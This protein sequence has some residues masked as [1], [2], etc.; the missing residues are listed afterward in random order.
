MNQGKLVVRQRLSMTGP[1][2]KTG[3]RERDGFWNNWGG[4][5][6]DITLPGRRILQRTFSIAGLTGEC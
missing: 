2:A 6:G 5:S 3:C 1:A 4:L